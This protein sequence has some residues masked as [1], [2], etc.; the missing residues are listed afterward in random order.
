M[1]KD[2]RLK[3]LLSAWRV[4]PP[5]VPDFNT[6]VWGRIDAEEERAAA[7]FWGTLRQWLFVQLPKPSYASALLV[8]TM[9]LGGTA[10]TMRADH[11][12]DQYRLENARRY[13]ASIDPIAMN[14]TGQSR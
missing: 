7:G 12:K 10:A 3:Q 14:A 1:N 2:P 13:L 6:S 4:S 8:V 9:V 11:M 5:P